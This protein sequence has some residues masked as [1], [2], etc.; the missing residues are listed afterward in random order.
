M[1]TS[2]HR[3]L[4]HLYAGKHAAIEVPVDGYRIDAVKRGE[5]IEVQHASLAAIR[6]KVTDLL[7]SHRVRVVKPIIATKQLLRRHKIDGPVISARR[8]PKRRESVDLFT[9]LMYFRNVFP[10]PSLRMEFPLVSVIE[11]RQPKKPRR[12]KGKDYRLIDIELVEV[13]SSVTLRTLADALNLI[14]LRSLAA[15]GPFDTQQLAQHVQ[16]PR[17]YAQQIAYCLKHM[18]AIRA[19]GKRR[20]AWLY[21][22]DQSSLKGGKP[23][24]TV[25]R[26]TSNRRKAG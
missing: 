4:K 20:A 25:R 22:L 17:W 7:Q 8:S 21:E 24:P 6:N 16:R 1:E 5:L 2:L 10:H 14:D 3:Q 13:L 23:I 26:P 9:E 11:H 18:G 15:A 12:W 19:V